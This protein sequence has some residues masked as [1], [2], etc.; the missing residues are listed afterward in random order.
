M[1]VVGIG[2]L[3]GKVLDKDLHAPN[4]RMILAKDTL[5]TARHVEVFLSWGIVEGSVYG[6]SH[7]REDVDDLDGHP[8]S[9]ILS[10]WKAGWG[11]RWI[12]RRARSIPEKLFPSSCPEL[13]QGDL[14]PIE[15]L[16][17]LE[18]GLASYSPVL[19]EIIDVIESP[20]SSAVHVAEVV[21]RDSALSA[22]LL[23]LVNSPIY[24]FPR[25]IKSIEQAVSIVGS[26]DL[27]ALVV[28]VSSI[29]YFRGISHKNL[30]MRSFWESSI[31]C[32]L[33]AR[34]LA[35]RRFRGDDS[36]FFVGGMLMNLGRLVMVQRMPEAFSIALYR[37]SRGASLLES[38]KSVFGYRSS[39]VTLSL[40]DRWFLPPDLAR[41]ITEARS[42]RVN[43]RKST[44]FAVAEGLSVAVGSGFA[45]DYYAPPVSDED[46]DFLGVT[47]N[48]LDFIMC[49]FNRQRAEIVDAFLG[50]IAS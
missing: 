8:P 50:G 48:E 5:V 1:T 31:S 30:D 20:F 12:S 34:L 41:S 26:N 29:A 39:D 13:S 17:Y 6:D 4:G 18:P 25:T 14:L 23:K 10:L 19:Q 38:E 7:D 2:S 3:E 42:T 36:H 16:L 37:A 21:A 27:M 43:D 22:R 28:Q 47:E 46:L 35:F 40:F 11:K 44:L 24:G 49:Q 32:A 45:G 15:S 9:P 33:F